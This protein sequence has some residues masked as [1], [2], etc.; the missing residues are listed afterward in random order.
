MEWL[1]ARVISGSQKALAK[2]NSIK[3]PQ[4]HTEPLKEELGLASIAGPLRNSVTTLI[5]ISILI[6]ILLLLLLLLLRFFHRH[7][8]DILKVKEKMRV[9]DVQYL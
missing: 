5:L 1:Y 9:H 3:S 4:D 2:K 7:G 6:L 8:P